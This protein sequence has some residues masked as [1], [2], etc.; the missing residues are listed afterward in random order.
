MSRQSVKPLPI[1]SDRIKEYIHKF[2]DTQSPTESAL[3]KLLGLFPLNTDLD[4]IVLKV[5]TLNSL[6]GTNVYDITAVARHI[7]TKNVDHR[8]EVGDAQVVKIIAEVNIGNKID[9]TVNED[10][11]VRNHYSFATKYCAW[12][13]PDKYPIF[14][15]YVQEILC[16]YRLRD[17][18]CDFYQYNLWV[19]PTLKQIIDV[20]QER[21]NL[22]A[23]GYKDLDKFLWLA[24]KECYPRQKKAKQKVK[25]VSEG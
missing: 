1:P 2:D 15:Y 16:G 3:K 17:Q 24:G 20:F 5:S 10:S 6:Y 23:F 13:N 12:H 8:I 22:T 14:D 25:I 9:N 19:Y 7:L 4:E 21:Y 18:F 11:K